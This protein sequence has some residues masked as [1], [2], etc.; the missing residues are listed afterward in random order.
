MARR[1]DPNG[2]EWMASGWFQ[3]LP[4]TQGQW[5]WLLLMGATRSRADGT[6]DALVE[7]GQRSGEKWFDTATG[8]LEA[9]IFWGFSDEERWRTAEIVATDQ[10]R[11]ERCV[12]ALGRLGLREPRTVRDLAWLMGALGLCRHEVDAG[13]ERWRVPQ[14]LPLPAEVLPMDEE[15]AR[16]SDEIRWQY[17]IAAITGDLAQLFTGELNRPDEVVTTI[18]E[19]ARLIDHDTEDVRHGLVDFAVNPLVF[20]TSEPIVSLTVDGPGGL[21]HAD[22]ER[23]ADEAPF[24][25]TFDWAALAER[26][27]RVHRLDPEH[28][29]E[30]D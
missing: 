15:W 10:L 17:Q 27:L 29:T 14:V 24:R 12:A 9:R 8:G 23:L 28:P 26:S 30:P 19:L 1:K 18:A 7:R 3:V 4:M 25:I 16:E 11:R 13:T 2:N 20:L 21:T 5:L 22:P 6:L